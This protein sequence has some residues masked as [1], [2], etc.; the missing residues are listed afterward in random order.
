V[1]EQGAAHLPP[2]EHPPAD[3]PRIQVIQKQWKAA[4]AKGLT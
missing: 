2:E 1:D 3:V 4:K